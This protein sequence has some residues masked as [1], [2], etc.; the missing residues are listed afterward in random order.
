MKTIQ[1]NTS[2]RMINMVKPKTRI[3]KNKKVGDILKNLGLNIIG[4]GKNDLSINHD[5]ILYK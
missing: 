4:T 5:N 3:K 2:K 1:L